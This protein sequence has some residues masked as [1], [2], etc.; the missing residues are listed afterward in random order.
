MSAYR[1]L[2]PGAE[3]WHLASYLGPIAFI[4]K[5]LLHFVADFLMLSPTRRRC[6]SSAERNPSNPAGK[7]RGS[8]HEDNF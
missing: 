4:G 3:R 6:L 7:N 2:G 8:P 1:I 5:R